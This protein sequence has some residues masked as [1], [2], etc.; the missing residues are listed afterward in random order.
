M[1]IQNVWGYTD[2]EVRQF[3]ERMK[4][5]LDRAKSLGI[6]GLEY[7]EVVFDPEATD[8]VAVRY[9]PHFDRFYANPSKMQGRDADIREALASRM[10]L[11]IFG[12]E[13]HV[14]WG[15]S[16]GLDGFVRI[17]S[18]MLAGKKIDPGFAGIM[19]ATT[20]IDRGAI[21][22]QIIAMEP[23]VP[24][25]EV[26]LTPLAIEKAIES[27]KDGNGRNLYGFYIKVGNVSFGS[28]PGFVTVKAEG[29]K[30]IVTFYSIGPK[31]AARRA[32]RYIYNAARKGGEEVA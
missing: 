11:A 29:E 24:N 18:D 3:V 5:A 19:A 26:K 8:G 1:T 9:D 25:R 20:G 13:E 7:G 14:E 28:G 17:F 23:P 12:P 30:D 15:E 16:R 4:N 2:G 6:D 31:T 32:S 10:W 22:E 21:S 27:M